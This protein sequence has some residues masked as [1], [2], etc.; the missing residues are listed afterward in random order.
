MPNLVEWTIHAMSCTTEP[1]AQRNLQ[2][3]SR[4]VLMAVNKV[5]ESAKVV[6]GDP[7]NP[8]HMQKVSSTYKA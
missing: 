5:I 2:S 6:A 4:A 8:A 7:K 1:E 3:A